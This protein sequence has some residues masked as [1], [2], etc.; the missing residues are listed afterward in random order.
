MTAIEPTAE[1]PFSQTLTQP[2]D[3]WVQMAALLN[4]PMELGAFL[5]ALP[6]LSSL[7]GGS[8]QPV[9]VMPGFMGDDTS[10]LPLRTFI[11]GW[12]HEV[13]GWGGDVNPGPTPAVL[14]ALEERL[15]QL[16]AEHGRKVSLLGWSAGGRYARHLARQHPEWVR[17]VITIA[18]ALQH[19]IG[20]D[21]SSISFIVDQVKHRFDPDFGQ[22]R[23]YALGP[24]PVPSTSIYTRLDGVIRWQT[25]LDEVDDQHENV[26]VYSSHVGVG[27]NP[28]VFYVIAD[29]LAQPEDD[30]RPFEPPDWLRSVYPRPARW[31][32]RRRLELQRASTPGAIALVPGAPPVAL[33]LPGV[34]GEPPA[35]SG[36]S[37]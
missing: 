19:R 30:W 13:Y 12:G 29:R 10:T 33:S 1:A 27:I 3:V 22:T 18:C 7:G 16:A 26:E 31:E 37:G 25:C 36:P 24:L 21:R 17:Q 14:A 2:P 9:L 4:V 5:A 15:A 11:R 32:P 8:Q 34:P 6:M 28:S 23:E 20:R 35:A